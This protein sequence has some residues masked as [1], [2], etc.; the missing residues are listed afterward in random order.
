MCI[1]FKGKVLNFAT[2]NNLSIIVFN[3]IEFSLPDHPHRRFNALTGDWVL[4]S[5]HRA[6]RPWQGQVE[7][8]QIDARPAY[9]AKCY[10]CPGNERSSGDDAPRPRAQ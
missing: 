8:A 6:K 7:K 5:P 2:D 4:V 1:D 10:L 9:D 3:M